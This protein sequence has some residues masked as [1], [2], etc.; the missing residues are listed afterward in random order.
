MR[1]I[2]I[3]TRGSLLALKQTQMAAC[4]IKKAYPDIE[5]EIV[6]ISTKGDSNTDKQLS[7][8]GGDGLFVREIEAALSKGLIDIA[9]HS[10]KDLPAVS[11]ARYEVCAVLKRGDVRDCIA[12]KKGTDISCI[13]NPVIGT[14]SRRRENL[15]KRFIPE[16]IVKP[17]RGNVPTRLKKLEK[18]EYDAVILAMAGL[19]RLGIKEDWLE[20][21]PFCEE[22]FVPAAN[23]GIIAVE[24]LK[25]S[26]AAV[27]LNK[28]DDAETHFLFDAQR[29]WMSAVG[30]GC[31]EAAG[32]Y[33]KT[34]AK[35]L[36][37]TCFYKDSKIITKTI[38]DKNIK[39]I[40]KTAK[41]L[42]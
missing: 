24:A 11:N 39:E 9:V 22:T 38:P 1:K 26:E 7:E 23:Q 29:L 31:H 33:I 42:L 18:G 5:T 25:E 40:V 32:V 17:L 28:I 21:I 14:G 3:G 12:F 6:K 13:E 8:L 36:E 4:E 30:A 34:T 10:G 15:I 20:I 2:K 16:C 41:E 37:L 19:E 27:L 35:T